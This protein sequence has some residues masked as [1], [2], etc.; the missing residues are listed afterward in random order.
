MLFKVIVYIYLN[1]YLKRRLA[2]MRKLKHEFDMIIMD[3]MIEASNSKISAIEEFEETVRKKTKNF[4]DI[5]LSNTDPINPYLTKIRFLPEIPLGTLLQCTHFPNMIRKIRDQDMSLTHLDFVDTR[6]G[7]TEYSLLEVAAM[8]FD[9]NTP[10]SA[11]SFIF[12]VE[13]MAEKVKEEKETVNTNLGKLAEHLDSNS[14]RIEHCSKNNYYDRPYYKIEIENLSMPKDIYYNINP[15]K[16][17][18][19]KQLHKEAQK[20]NKRIELSN[21]CNVYFFT[22]EPYINSSFVTKNEKPKKSVISKLLNR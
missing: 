19:F 14:H 3:R 16:L 10:I 2:P 18:G 17:E 12:H 15:E 22:R 7:E 4:E 21:E 20:I 6:K 11:S 5:L 8:H 9:T 1:N 13:K